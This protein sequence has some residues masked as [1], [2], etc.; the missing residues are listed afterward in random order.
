MIF[1]KHDMEG[2]LKVAELKKAIWCEVFLVFN[3]PKS[4][5][6]IMLLVYIYVFRF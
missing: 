5:A 6:A 1:H 2:E 3:D 4:G